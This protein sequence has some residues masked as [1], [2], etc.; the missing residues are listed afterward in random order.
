MDAA[1]ALEWMDNAGHGRPCRAMVA[2]ASGTMEAAIVGNR[3]EF[4]LHI[5]GNQGMEDRVEAVNS[6]AVGNDN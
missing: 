6:V 1:A 5:D 2:A 3:E 4:H